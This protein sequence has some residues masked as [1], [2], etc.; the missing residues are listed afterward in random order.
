MNPFDY[1]INYAVKNPL[2][3]FEILFFAVIFFF[4]IREGIVWYWKIN[5]IVDLL[6]KIE[7]NTNNKNITKDIDKKVDTQ[8]VREIK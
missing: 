8:L 7:Q 5:N 2:A 4:I 3:S 1:V 6:E